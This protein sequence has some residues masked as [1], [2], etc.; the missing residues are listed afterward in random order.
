MR[1]LS[2]VA[3]ACALACLFEAV[4][5]DEHHNVITYCDQTSRL[6]TMRYVIARDGLIDWDGG[7]SAGLTEQVLVRASTEGF[8]EVAKVPA[9]RGKTW[10]HPVLVGGVVYVRNAEEAAAYR[11]AD[12]PAG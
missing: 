5:F 4:A 9:I 3:P 7:A 11:L 12:P 2:L 6:R 1:T 10:N 8:E